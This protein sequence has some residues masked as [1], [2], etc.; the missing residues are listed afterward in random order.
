MEYL[1]RPG[2]VCTALCGRRV[3][4]PTR[5]ASAA[6]KSALPLTMS[7]FMIW[8]AIEQDE[9]P[10]KL[11]ELYGAFSRVEPEEQKKRIE[12]FCEKLLELGFVIRKEE[13]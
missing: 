8:N 4:I 3:L 11:L 13:A 9:S 2:V 10:E 1:P 12:E 5:L 6:C 7:G